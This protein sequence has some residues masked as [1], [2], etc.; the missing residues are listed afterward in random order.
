VLVLVLLLIARIA[1]ASPW[2]VIYW[3]ISG[4]VGIQAVADAIVALLYF[5]LS[6]AWRRLHHGYSHLPQHRS[7]TNNQEP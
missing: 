3:R 6:V 4:R 7:Q 2:P 1:G 5:F